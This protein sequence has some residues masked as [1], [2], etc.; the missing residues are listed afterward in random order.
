MMDYS[1]Y[2]AFLRTRNKEIFSK[3]EKC[4][5]PSSDIEADGYRLYPVCEVHLINTHFNLQKGFEL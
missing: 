1:E 2:L 4:G 5:K 3:C